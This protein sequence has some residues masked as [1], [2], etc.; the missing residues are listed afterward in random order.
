MHISFFSPADTESAVGALYELN[1][2]YFGEAASSRDDARLTLGNILSAESGVR[3]VVAKEEDEIAG[4]ATISLLYPA[5]ESRGQLFLKDLYVCAKWRG[6]GVGEALMRFLASYAVSKNCIR[7]DW[8]TES[9][10]LG[11]LAFYERLG[12]KRVEEK[13]YFRLAGDSLVAFAESKPP[14]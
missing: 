8:T 10:N 4:L 13:V 5:P 6:S 3:M 9:T 12:A 1:C 7:F 2:H 14:G 11:A